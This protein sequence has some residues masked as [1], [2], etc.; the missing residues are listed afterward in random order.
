MVEST[1]RAKLELEEKEDPVWRRNLD[2]WLKE[3]GEGWEVC[4]P[5]ADLIRCPWF[6][7][8]PSRER[9]ALAALRHANPQKLGHN[10]SQQVFR[11]DNEGPEMV[12]SIGTI[13]PKEKT[14]CPQAMR[15]ILGAELLHIQGMPYD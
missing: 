1:A 3:R 14:Y 9:C 15:L 6:Q 11:G 5:S 12:H 10:V 4:R 7:I 2:A 13:C 8:L